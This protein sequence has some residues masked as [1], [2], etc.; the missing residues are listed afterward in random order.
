MANIKERLERIEN[1]NSERIIAV[2]VGKHYNDW[3]DED[4]RP[5]HQRNTVLSRDD[6]L[7][8]LD[9]EYDNGYGGADCFPMYAWTQN[10]IIVILEYDGSTGI[11]CIPRNPIDCEPNFL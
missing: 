10:W 5:T 1:K 7:A 6:G 4:R 11:G 8:L 3:F 2:V 9:V